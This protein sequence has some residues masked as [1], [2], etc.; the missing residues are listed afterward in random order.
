M[1]HGT[2]VTIWYR[3]HK[4]KYRDIL[5]NRLF[6]TALVSTRR[7]VLRQLMVSEEE[8][9]PASLQA[10]WA[11]LTLIRPSWQSAEK[12]GVRPRSAPMFGADYLEV[13]ASY[14]SILTPMIGL[15]TRWGAAI[16]FK[17]V[18]FLSGWL[19]HSFSMKRIIA[20]QRNYS[21][22]VLKN[23]YGHILGYLFLWYLYCIMT[24]VSW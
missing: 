17:L 15:Q 18:R 14:R 5:P 3:Y 16:I 12:S 24:H 4:N 8:E 13:W 19:C 9:K 20:N 1:Y 10:F 2:R 23:R 7:P 11:G 6:S 21:R 22:A